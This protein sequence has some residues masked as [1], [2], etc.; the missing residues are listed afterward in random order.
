MVH[1]MKSK[2][3]NKRTKHAKFHIVNSESL[4]RLRW[5]W[6]H[7]QQKDLECEIYNWN[8]EYINLH[9]HPVGVFKAR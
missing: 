6:K 4:M 7:N 2:L 5:Y 8:C 3:G 1:I 9:Q